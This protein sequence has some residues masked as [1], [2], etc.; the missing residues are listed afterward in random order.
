MTGGLIFLLSL[1]FAA[2]TDGGIG[3]FIL[4]AVLLNI[5]NGIVRG[6]IRRVNPQR[7]SQRTPPRIRRERPQWRLEQ[8]WEQQQRRFEQ[9]WEEQQWGEGGNQRQRGRGRGRANRRSD[10]RDDRYA[11]GRQ[12]ES[13]E[14][15]SLPTPR[16]NTGSRTTTTARA[17]S[18]STKA[19]VY[20]HATE[21]V[22][23]AGLNPDKAGLTLTD[24]GLIVYGA[25]PRPVVHRESAVPDTAN[26]VQPF[27]ELK[28]NR[29]AKGRLTFEVVD[30]SGQVA[31]RREEEQELRAGKTAVI[32]RTRLPIGDHFYLAQGWTL[33]I[34]ANDVLLAEHPFGWYNPAS[35]TETLREVMSND[36]E[37]TADLSALMDDIVAQPM[38]LDDLLGDDSQA[39]KQKQ[40]RR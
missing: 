26:Y 32:S 29:A 39:Q 13:S 21:A 37:L 12:P 35:R 3:A 10:E 22:R 20:P 33:K 9:M 31:Y 18:P 11:R 34:Y 23:R 24:V 25:E 28:A 1:V 2:A 27:A 19:Q 4:A 36:G 17:A 16:S 30:S 5:A 6:I 14:R 7:Q 15:P 40:A 8:F 38:S